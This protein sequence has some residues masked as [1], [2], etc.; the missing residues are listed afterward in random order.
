MELR[1]ANYRELSRDHF[2]HNELREK[3]V[4]LKKQMLN[5][6]INHNVSQPTLHLGCD[7]LCNS[8]LLPH[9]L[10]VGTVCHQKDFLK[11]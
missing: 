6:H 5:T 2:S 7:E 9:D 8:V 4:W 10:E 1:I 3:S 11:C